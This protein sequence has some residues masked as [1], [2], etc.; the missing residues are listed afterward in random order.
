MLMVVCGLGAGSEPEVA[1]ARGEVL[2]PALGQHQGLRGLVPVPP[3]S[4]QGSSISFVKNPCSVSVPDSGMLRIRIEGFAASVSIW[5][6]IHT[7]SG[8]RPVVFMTK[9][10]KISN[11]NLLGKKMY[12]YFFA[13]R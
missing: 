3:R 12:R 10:R 7:G 13:K 1:E 9:I 5:L 6:R 2:P 11:F 4:A 8:S